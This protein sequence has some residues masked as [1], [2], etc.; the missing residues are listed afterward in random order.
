M[1]LADE[2]EKLD[3]LK[4]NGT[5]TEEEFQ[6]AKRRLLQNEPVPPPPPSGGYQRPPMSQADERMWAMFI[7]LGLLCGFLVPG[8]GLV[9]PIVLWQ[10]KKNESTFID[11]NGKMVA[12]W[13]ITFLIAAAICI[14]L[15]VILIGGL[16]LLALMAV[17]VIF[18][19]IGAIK[20]N[21]GELWPYPISFK[22][23]Q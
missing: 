5:I 2:L 13:I 11:Q 12:N 21:N 19:I 10:L 6:A 17:N 9:V 16:L 22:F 18:A 8:L 4:A 3:R 15:T 23:I 20:A 1:S 14:V 7:H